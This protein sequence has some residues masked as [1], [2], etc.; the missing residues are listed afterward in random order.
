MPA[1]SNM[2]SDSS[3][4][5]GSLRTEDADAPPSLKVV[6]RKAPSLHS[7]VTAEAPVG[8]ASEQPA[9]PC[10]ATNSRFSKSTTVSDWPGVKLYTTSSLSSATKPV[11]K[12]SGI[13][14]S[15]RGGMMTS[16]STARLSAS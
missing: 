13:D 15:L 12:R 5:T 6:V 4:N 14:D 1:F 16:P 3:A 7:D 8:I 10:S 11:A 2:G 9:M